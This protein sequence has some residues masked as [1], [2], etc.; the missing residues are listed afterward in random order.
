MKVSTY[1]ASW[2]RELPHNGLCLEL[3]RSK[4]LGAMRFS[5]GLKGSV[6]L[7]VVRHI[8]C[9]PDKTEGPC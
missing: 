3:W 9:R 1:V 8:Y 4:W 5:P 7:Y 2:L 6:F